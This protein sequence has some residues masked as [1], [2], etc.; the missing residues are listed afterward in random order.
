[1]KFIGETNPRPV[2][3]RA[4]KGKAK[5]NTKKKPQDS[6]PANKKLPLLP[7]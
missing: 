3:S 4:V 5:A 7:G 6:Q 2:I 1:M